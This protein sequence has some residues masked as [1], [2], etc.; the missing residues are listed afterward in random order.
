MTGNFVKV[1]A[2]MDTVCTHILWVGSNILCAF[3]NGTFASL[4]VRDVVPT[5]V[6][7]STSSTKE[8]KKSSRVGG[9]EEGSNTE[10]KDAAAPKR[11]SKKSATTN[12]EDRDEDDDINFEEDDAATKK[13][14]NFFIDDEADEDEDNGDDQLGQKPDETSLD[15][16]TNDEKDDDSFGVQEDDNLDDGAEVAVRPRVAHFELPEPQPAFAPSSTALE[17]TRRIM[18]WNHMGTITLLRGDDS[19]APRNTVDISFTDSAFRRPVTFTDNMDFI[20]GSLGEDGALFATD[21]ADDDVDGDDELDD[22]VDGLNMSAITKAAV[23]KSQRKRM[24]K[25]GNTSSGSSIYFHRFETFGSL[26]NKD[27]VLTLPDGELAVGC[28]CGEGWAACIT[29]RRFL[30]F[31]S[32]G[33]NQG[34]VIWLAGDPVTIVGRSKFVAV[35]YHEG[36]PF[37]DGTQKLGYIIYD[38]ITCEIIVSGS[39]SCISKRSSLNWAGFSK[40]GSLMAMDSDGMLSMLV[41]VENQDKG[42]KSF[43]WNWA[44]ML[45]TVGLRK[46]LE[47]SF[48]P[49]TVQDGK[50]VCVP[51]RGGNEHP[52]AARRPVTTALNLRM[53]F[54]YSSNKT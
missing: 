20:I 25:E 54:A 32:A 15:D 41:A 45:D 2:E 49:V 38:G 16:R 35:F 48:W 12:D 8:T 27:W 51:L 9:E 21:L 13:A 3:A 28:A 39:L 29:N 5:D 24:K 17:F 30:R 22:V 14:K 44:P 40:E 18:C 19:G 43:S 42:N 53:P 10:L 52:D 50:F 6:P 1:N 23:R 34:P 7:S 33:G 46:S 4:D 47:D 11:L 31:F 26:N 36:L 37:A